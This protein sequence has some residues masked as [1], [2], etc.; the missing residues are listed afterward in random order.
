VARLERRAPDAEYERIGG[1]EYDFLFRDEAAG[2]AAGETLDECAGLSRRSGIPCGR[3]DG[4]VVVGIGLERGV[5]LSELG[6]VD[7]VLPADLA[8]RAERDDAAL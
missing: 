3:D 8:G 7:A 4:Y 1:D 6:A 5:Q 2:D